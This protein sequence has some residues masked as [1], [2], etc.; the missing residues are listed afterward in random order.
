MTEAFDW[1]AVLARGPVPK[2]ADYNPIS[3]FMDGVG[4]YVMDDGFR[5]FSDAD[6][7][8]R[9]YNKALMYK[10]ADDRRQ[11]A[12]QHYGTDDLYAT[13]AGF[14]PK[15]K[16]LFPESPPDTSGFV[17]GGTPT[18]TR[19]QAEYDA[20][21]KA[22]LPDLSGTLNQQFTELVNTGG[23][24]P[25]EKPSS[26]TGAKADGKASG[27]DDW[28]SGMQFN[29]ALLPSGFDW[30]TYVSLNP[31]LGAAGIDTETEAKR[32]YATYGKNESRHY[33]DS[34]E[35]QRALNEYLASRPETGQPTERAQ[36]FGITQTTSLL[37]QLRAM[38]GGDP[39]NWTIQGIDRSQELAGLLSAA[40]VT[41]LSSLRMQT[42]SPQDYL[43]QLIAM[44]QFAP[45]RHGFRYT[46][47]THVE[48]GEGSGQAVYLDPS[49]PEN[50]KYVGGGQPLQQLMAGDTALGYLG[51]IG[52]G[53]QFEGK[54]LDWLR[55]NDSRNQ[56]RLAQSYAGK[57]GV[58]YS[59][60]TMPDGSV[61][62]VPQWQSSSDAGRVQDML[63]AAAVIAATAYGVSSLGGGLGGGAATDA[64]A[65]SGFVGEGAMSGIPGWDAATFMGDGSGF[66]GEMALGDATKAALY[67]NAGYGAPMSGWQTSVFDAVLSQ[68][69]SAQLADLAASLVPHSLGDA[70][71]SLGKDILKDAAKEAIVGDNTNSS[72]T[73]SGGGITGSNLLGTWMAYNQYENA[74]AD[75]DRAWKDYLAA[76]EFNKD[77]IDRIVGNS[78]DYKSAIDNLLKPDS[79]PKLN[80][81]AGAFNPGRLDLSSRDGS[82]INDPYY[83]AAQSDADSQMLAQALARMGQADSALADTRDAQ[84]AILR[85]LAGLGARTTYG[86]A[87]V[88]RIA[89]D[90]YGKR[91]GAL[92]RALKMASSQGFAGTITRGLSDSTQAGDTRDE[93]VRRFADKYGELDAQSWAEAA[94]IV[95]NYS[96]LQ[97]AQRAAAMAEAVKANNPELHAQIAQWL[98]GSADNLMGQYG[99]LANA[100][101]NR[102]IQALQSMDT[103]DLNDFKARFDTESKRFDDATRRDIS[104]YQGAIQSRSSELGS[105][106]S[107]LSSNERLAAELS[108]GL[109]RDAAGNYQA[110]RTAEGEMLAKLISAGSPLLNAGNG[111]LDKAI[112]KGGD[113][114][115]GKIGDWIDGWF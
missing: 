72:K 77:Q 98:T 80:N 6:K 110:T 22:R 35:A 65:A 86:E 101:A 30:Q 69:G 9:E 70:A 18:G 46:G 93:I 41:D 21:Q 106:L 109:T 44:E 68:T 7:A 38:W 12:V 49:N 1:Q 23:A 16:S 48:S 28:L 83:K 42:L 100:E 96:Q 11:E 85:A 92:D 113:W 64:G 20:K 13:P 4:G 91:V 40:G 25:T 78:G 52:S 27:I 37:D 90:L 104:A 103:A 95:G 14:I 75:K 31:D 39:A 66:V 115:L 3:T 17:F 53:G 63:K 55:L 10:Q 56:L 82:W 73:G 47:P 84:D 111:L 81:T 94:G 89:G 5:P 61:R 29:Q 76:Q 60:V 99:Q 114:A 79:L 67:S 102:L 19:T 97:E 71:K 45:E 107:A 88:S 58:S 2:P 26:A 36:G 57:G 32:H 62:I 112:D 50:W 59:V 105:L 87:D 8:Y 34:P 24:G 33:V 51:T 54:E 43:A 15:N 74:G 108:G